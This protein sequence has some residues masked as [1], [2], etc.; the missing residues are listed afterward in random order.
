MKF[1]SLS[2][3]LTSC[4][5]AVAASYTVSALADATNSSTNTVQEAPASGDQAPASVGQGDSSMPGNSSMPGA[6]NVGSSDDVTP[7]TATGDDDY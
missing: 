3:F 2:T 5:L 6:S 4:V 7:D 1:K